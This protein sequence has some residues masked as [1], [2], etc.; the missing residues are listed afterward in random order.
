MAALAFKNEGVDG[1]VDHPIKSGD[2][3]DGVGGCVTGR[4]G[5]Y[6]RPFF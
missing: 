4:D 6:E 1:R 3:H 2:G 5:S